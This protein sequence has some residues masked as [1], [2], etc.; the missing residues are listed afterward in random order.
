MG[1][2]FQSQFDKSNLY[3]VCNAE[4]LTKEINIDDSDEILEAKWMNL[5]EYFTCEDIHIY[6]KNLVKAALKNEGLKLEN[7]KYFADVDGQHEFYF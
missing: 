1:Y 6:N 3:I 5:D 2:F 4:A 7:H